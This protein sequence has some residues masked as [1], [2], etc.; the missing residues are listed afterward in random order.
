MRSNIHRKRFG[1]MSHDYVSLKIRT[2]GKPGK[3]LADESAFLSDNLDIYRRLLAGEVV[4][5]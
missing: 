5:L 1:I 4:K 3:Y 2:T